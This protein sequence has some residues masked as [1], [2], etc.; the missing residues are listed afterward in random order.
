MNSSRRFRAFTGTPLLRAVL[1]CCALYGGHAFVANIN[2]G[3]RAGARGRGLD[4]EV[5]RRVA[6][7]QRAQIQTALAMNAG[8]GLLWSWSKATASVLAAVQVRAVCCCY[9]CPV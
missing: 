6:L 1:C 4:R 5:R 2:A 9:M 8:E 3:C 7:P